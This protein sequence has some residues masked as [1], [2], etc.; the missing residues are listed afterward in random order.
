MKALMTEK[1]INQD[2][3]VKQLKSDSINFQEKFKNKIN[4][5]LKN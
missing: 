3:K 2:F 4:V 1:C 5:K